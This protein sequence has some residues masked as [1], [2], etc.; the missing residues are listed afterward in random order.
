MAE[1][2][3]RNKLSTSGEAFNIDQQFS[4]KPKKEKNQH[5]HK[6][7]ESECLRHVWQEVKEM[8]SVMSDGTS[9]TLLWFMIM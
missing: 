1:H 3:V 2:S 5:D 7:A 6:P 8:L 4:L 9:D